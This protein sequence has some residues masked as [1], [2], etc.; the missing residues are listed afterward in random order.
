MIRSVAGD[1]ANGM[2]S[3]Q[4]PFRDPH[5]SSSMAALIGGGSQAKPGEVS[6]AH[7]GV[8]FL[9]ELAEFPRPVLDSL[10]Q[11]I[12]TGRAVISRANRHVTY[13]AQFQLI[14]AMNPCRCGYLTDPS[15]ACAR[16]P[17]CA[18]D[19]QARLS[20]PLLDRFDLSIEVTAV[21]IRHLSQPPARENSAMVAARVSHARSQQRRRAA[22][23]GYPETLLNAQVDGERLE[24]VAPLDADCRSLIDTAAEQLKLTA[25]GFHRVIKVART[26]ADLE[27]QDQI[28]RQHVAEALAYRRALA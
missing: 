27:N 14:A 12:E 21:D 5:H 9:D 24:V 23:L 3:R 18:Q 4:R 22:K 7:R 28:S 16:A 19:Y 8:L 2:I 1:L 26:L 17:R 20:G 25:R 10:R 13:P 11:P 15:Q 6:L